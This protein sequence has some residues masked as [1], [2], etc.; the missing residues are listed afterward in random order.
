MRGALGPTKPLISEK[1]KLQ[2]EGT[3]AHQSHTTT[4]AHFEDLK[5]ILS[6]ETLLNFLCL[7]GLK[8]K[9]Q[10]F[11]PGLCVSSVTTDSK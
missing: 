4:P 8:K 3:L 6:N 2:H 9:T 5:R 7:K 10:Y 1:N 11:C